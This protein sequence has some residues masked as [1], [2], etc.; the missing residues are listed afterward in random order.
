[1]SATTTSSPKL[2][3]IHLVGS[4]GRAI[5]HTKLEMDVFSVAEAVRAIDIVTNGK[6][7]TYLGGPARDKLYR[8]AIQKRDNVIG[9][10]ELHHRS[11][12]STIYIM[13][14]I[15]GR[16]SGAGKILA[17]IGILA[18]TYF[19]G[20]LGA[21]LSGWAGAGA[22]AT[23]GASLSFLGTVA[24]GFGVS[25]LIGGITQLLTPK[26]QGP[27]ETAEQAQSTSF[28][29]NATAVVQGG[30]V[31][32]VYGRALMPAIPISITVSNDNVPITDAGNL[33][34][35]TVTPL[36]GGG[37]DYTQNDP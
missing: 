13:P 35:V 9:K 1:M 36:P 29:G 16:N 5:G 32:V 23:A 18:L 31:P 12:R 3:T 10:E 25:L 8:I 30:C 6:L 34:T 33:G 26:P 7:S 17:G 15:R 2:T 20:G 19:T 37:I 24:V 4:L 22:T 14:T 28:A 11:G 21:G 27:Q